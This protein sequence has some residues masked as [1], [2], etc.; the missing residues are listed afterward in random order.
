MQRNPH[1]E[2]EAAVEPTPQE[3]LEKY[4]AKEHGAAIV[5]RQEQHLWHL[6]EDA[7]DI[8]PRLG[9]GVLISERLDQ[10]K[11]HAD[12]L[13]PTIVG[14][15][16]IHYRHELAKL[17]RMSVDDPAQYRLQS[18][19]LKV[20]AMSTHGSAII[21]AIKAVESI[22]RA[23]PHYYGRDPQQ[24]LGLRRFPWPDESIPLRDAIVAVATRFGTLLGLPQDH[25]V[26]Q[27]AD[28]TRQAR[29][30]SLAQQ[31]P[32]RSGPV[33]SNP[34]NQFE[35]ADLERRAESMLSSLTSTTSHEH[36]QTVDDLLQDYATLIKDRRGLACVKAQRQLEKI[37]AVSAELQ[38]RYSKV[39]HGVRR[40]EH[41][42]MV[43]LGT[44]CANF[45]RFFDAA[46]PRLTVNEMLWRKRTSS[47]LFRASFEQCVVALSAILTL[48]HPG[49]CA[50]M[51]PEQFHTSLMP[52][53][54]KIMALSTSGQALFHHVRI[55]HELLDYGGLGGTELPL[56][57]QRTLLDEPMR[58]LANRPQLQSAITRVVQEFGTALRYP[59]DHNPVRPSQEDLPG[60]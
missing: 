7:V 9:T 48:L 36:M 27:L 38:L 34:E 8:N 22:E 10:L 58:S 29:I 2:A 19:A 59:T 53:E 18:E 23:K 50:E 51:G 30:A 6:V 16:I 52:K 11:R 12:E 40:L 35:F 14:D 4:K 17:D 49:S 47:S 55:L 26:S 33:N 37:R 31:V 32:I 54:C 60:R 41:M 25:Q 28:V 21:R 57:E 46:N 24:Y 43:Y 45:I 56:P 42:F 20:V 5:Y 3:T 13:V 39:P 44:A 1:R 15:W